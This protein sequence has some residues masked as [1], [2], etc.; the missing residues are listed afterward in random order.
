MY[1]W[2]KGNQGGPEGGD[3]GIGQREGSRMQRVESKARSV[4]FV[5]YDPHSLG[6]PYFPLELEAETFVVS[7]R[8]RTAP[9]ALAARPTSPGPRGSGARKSAT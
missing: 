7:L 6:P 2:F 8:L 3:L 5:T 9:R 4:Q 1:T